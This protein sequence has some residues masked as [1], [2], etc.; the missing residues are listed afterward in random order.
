MVDAEDAIAAGMA[1]K[2][3]TLDQTLARFG[4]SLPASSQ[5]RA[6]AYERETRALRFRQLVGVSR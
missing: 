6:I 1:D 3:G 5:R 4:A 2:I